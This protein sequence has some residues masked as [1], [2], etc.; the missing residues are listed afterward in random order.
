MSKNGP[1]VLFVFIFSLGFYTLCFTE[2]TEEENQITETELINQILKK[3]D[4][5]IAPPGTYNTTQKISF[6]FVLLF[7]LDLEEK[8]GILSTVAVPIMFWKDE[9]L[10]WNTEETNGIWYIRIPRENIWKP[11]FSV[12]NRGKM[13][14]TGTNNPI[15]LSSG[16]T[17]TS[18]FLEN[19]YSVC[20]PDLRYFPFDQQNCDIILGSSELEANMLSIEPLNWLPNLEHHII[21]K[22]YTENNRWHLMKAKMEYRNLDYM[23][24]NSS[25]HA[26]V[27][28][29]SIKRR[30]PALALCVLTPLLLS[31]VLSLLTFWIPPTSSMRSAV[32]V[33]AV[34]ATFGV[35]LTLAHILPSTAT[36]RP[37]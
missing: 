7:I 29:F 25:Y 21:L 5:N 16:G 28:T 27:V 6:L 24:S 15:L 30:T 22:N 10:F 13:E 35:L 3:L 18:P 11:Q 17:L 4:K 1:I 14:E 20:V 9:R 37:I 23:F 8:T 36:S 31:L 2:R 34:S 12:L 32:A 33:T 19:I 26:V